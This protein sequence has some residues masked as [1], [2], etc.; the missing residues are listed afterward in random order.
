MGT[1][2]I[3]MH[4]SQGR[5]LYCM[6]VLFPVWPRG[7]CFM[8]KLSS[9]LTTANV[10]SGLFGVSGCQETASEPPPV[11]KATV[12]DFDLDVPDIDPDAS[13]VLLAFY[14]SIRLIRSQRGADAIRQYWDCHTFAR[15]IYGEQFETL[16]PEDQDAVARQHETL[17]T[18]MYTDP[19]LA[20][21]LSN[22]EVEK[23]ATTREEDL[24]HVHFDVHM[25]DATQAK[26]QR[27]VFQTD[28]DTCRVIDVAHSVDDALLSDIL[29]VEWKSTGLNPLEYAQGMA[30][31]LPGIL[32]TIKDED[33][34]PD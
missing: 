12:S 34:Q 2:S 15:R 18:E 6:I 16:S 1:N 13:K 14:D 28:G 26:R 29:R 27:W 20:S 32:D 19:R 4:D 5:A 25:G 33:L 22:I 21:F 9:L 8:R 30:G 11:A 17:R 10:V 7:K 31:E 23:V 24:I 3:G